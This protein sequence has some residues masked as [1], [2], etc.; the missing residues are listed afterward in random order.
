MRQ[1]AS[2]GVSAKPTGFLFP[3]PSNFNFEIPMGANQSF[4]M[5]VPIK[6]LDTTATL[7]AAQS[8]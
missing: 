3:L 8:D 6:I 2:G 5:L 4:T 7:M 1:L